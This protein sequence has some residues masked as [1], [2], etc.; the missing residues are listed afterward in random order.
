MTHPD[1][2]VSLRDVTKHYMQ[3][4]VV[5]QSGQ[6]QR[7]QLVKA[8]DGVSLDIRRGEI[9]GLIGESGCGK[10]TLARLMINL[11]QPT[12]GLIT[13][14]G[15]STRDIGR[16]DQLAFRRKVQLIFQNPYD[17]FDPRD[18]IRQILMAPLK[19]HSIGKTPEEQHA[20]CLEIL[21]RAGLRPAEDY[22]SRYPHE[23]SGGQLQRISILRSMLL[24]PSFV[25][26]DEPVS[27][28]DVSIRAD[29]IN[30]LELLSREKNASMVF[31]SH[32][33]STT[34]YISHK[35]AVMYLG[36]IVEHGM[37]D[38]VLHRPIHPYTRAL[39]S[40]SASINPLE[41]KDVIRI[42]GEPPTPIGTGPGCYFEP[43]CY[44]RQER[45]KHEYPPMAGESHQY[46]C[47]YAKED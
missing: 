5:S 46:S 33:I 39:I 9:L 41:K 29:I 27:M 17:I 12:K 3:K 11:E 23:L 8:V 13:I 22:I 28:L 19:L 16:T 14:G 18:S 4:S 45:C 10:S 44:L 26:A 40:N 1:I 47:F 15:V 7:R 30:M 2:V 25:V 43:R 31:I 42:D 24:D 32:D 34:R 6:R 20:I 35:V 36:R 21:E 37:T 38:D